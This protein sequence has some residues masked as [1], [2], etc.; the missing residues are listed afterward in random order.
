MDFVPEV[1]VVDAFVTDQDVRGCAV[2]WDT[3][4]KI[5]R[6]V[7]IGQLSPW[8]AAGLARSLANRLQEFADEWVFAE[9][10]EPEDEDDDDEDA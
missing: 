4:T 1:E 3:A 10:E 2:L 7:I 8:E 9:D 6:M 5:P